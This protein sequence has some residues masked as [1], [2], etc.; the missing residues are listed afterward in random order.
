MVG[1]LEGLIAQLTAAAELIMNGALV[2]V[3]SLGI[4]SLVITALGV[5]LSMG[6]AA[7][8]GTLEEWKGSLKNVAMVMFVEMI[9]TVCPGGFLL[10][11][12]EALAAVGKFLSDLFGG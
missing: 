4:V 9:V 2:I 10:A 5:L 8:R 1:F 12:P 6:F 7:W 3:A 11:R